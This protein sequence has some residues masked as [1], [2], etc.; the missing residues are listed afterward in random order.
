MSSANKIV[1]LG[2]EPAISVTTKHPSWPVIDADYEAA[3]NKQLHESISIYN[4][5]GIIE[6]F[7]N[8]FAEIHG[9]KYALLN[10]SGT[11]SIWAMF[12]GAGLQPG[13]E[14]LCPTYTFFATNTPLLSSGLVPVFC[15]ADENGNIN[16][17]DMEHRINSKTKAIIITHMWG[18]PCDMDRIVEIA[19]K[20]NLLLFEDCSHAHL[21]EYKNK[22][23]GS[24]GDAAAWSLQGQKNITGGEGGI[25]LTNDQD[26]YI[27]ANLLGHYNKR[28]K[29][30]IPVTHPLYRFAVTGMGLKM[31]SHPLAV[32]FADTQLKKYQ[33]YQRMRDR[34]A[35][36]YDELLG[37]YPYIER[38]PHAD[39]KPSWYAYVFKYVQP[40]TSKVTR[41]KLV[42]LLHEEGLIEVDI[43]GSTGPNHLL[44]IF[45]E[46]SVL[47]PHF[48]TAG[49]QFNVHES[50]HGA[51]TFYSTVVKL[52][53]WTQAEHEVLIKG[54]VKGLKK[55]LD[56]VQSSC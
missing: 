19:K 44:P 6:E 12:V 32:A 5:S 24:F 21:A 52:P 14:V 20:H 55:V 49:K 46:P 36:D 27:R 22:R 30:E 47:F 41:Q 16:P 43:P 50:F 15:D 31:R 38:I 25:L 18:Y 23:V 11:N 33:S 1:S 48:Y 8:A 28:C 42:A 13:D 29:D 45:Q 53:T 54:Y 2:G 37:K 40:K 4:R 7:E 17:E 26:I 39:T 51:N 35:K 34:C 56:H 9:R 3:V 10:N